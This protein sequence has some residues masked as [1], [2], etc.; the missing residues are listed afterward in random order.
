MNSYHKSYKPWLIAEEA[1]SS[2][3]LSE[4]LCTVFFF[5]TSSKT[6]FLKCERLQFHPFLTKILLCRG[7]TEMRSASMS[8]SSERVCTVYVDQ[9]HSF[10]CFSIQGNTY[11]ILYT[12]Q[13]ARDFF[14][15]KVSA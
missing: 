6:L 14:L 4:Q 7:K 12:I 10:R 9:Q 5:L 3:R 1:T 2:V 11:T 13:A 15:S 8:H